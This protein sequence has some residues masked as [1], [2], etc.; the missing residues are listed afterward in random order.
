MNPK[1]IFFYLVCIFIALILIAPLASAQKTKKMSKIDPV[2]T[3][4]IVK[5]GTNLDVPKNSAVKSAVSI[6]GNVN[7]AG[8]V[9]RDAVAIGGSVILK[10]SA[11]VMGNA[12][13]VGGIVKKMPGAI[14]TGE[15]KEVSMPKYV[16]A[17]TVLGAKVGPSLALLASVFLGLL[18]FLGILA[19]GVA[20]GLVFPKRV[21]WTA[22]SI[23]Q[24]PVKAFLWGLLWI[25]LILPIAFLLFVSIIG[26]PLIIAEVMVYGIALV[27][28]YV[29]ATQVIGKKLLTAF[30]RYNMP[31][32]TEIIWGIVILTL[33]GIV[34]VIGPLV[35]AII[36]TMA[37]GA[38][39]MSR[40]GE[41]A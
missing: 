1:R 12:V 18:Y 6:G 10:P 4:D 22:V 26:I 20:A 15:I 37:L 36:C 28:G 14:V 40:F 8:N 32:V 2:L 35:H 27:L 13:S 17:I 5:V 34:P 7:V 21:G 25:V 11:K 29:A 19:V 38:S 33:I 23:D 41:S 16:S 9:I 39:W 3:P 30:K 24:H 31:M